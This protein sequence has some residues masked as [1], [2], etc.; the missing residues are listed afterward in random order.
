MNSFYVRCKNLRLTKTS[1]QDMHLKVYQLDDQFCFKFIVFV[2]LF[3]KKRIN[4]T[5]FVSNLV[6]WTKDDQHY[7]IKDKIDRPGSIFFKLSFLI[8]WLFY[9]CAKSN[10]FLATHTLV[11]HNTAIIHRF[12]NPNWHE[13]WKQKNAQV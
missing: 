13:L 9:D 7:Q 11:G 10:H 1:L 6:L 8:N 4:N 2:L 12:L 5:K 3:T